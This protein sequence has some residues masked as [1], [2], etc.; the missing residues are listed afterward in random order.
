MDAG[1]VLHEESVAGALALARGVRGRV[2]NRL[3][4]NVAKLEALFAPYHRNDGGYGLIEPEEAPTMGG[5]EFPQR[6]DAGQAGVASAP[7]MLWTTV[8]DG[9]IAW[10]A[11]RP[12]RQISEA[13]EPDSRHRWRLS[14]PGDRRQ[15]HGADCGR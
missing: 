5:R 1:A 3:K 9:S 14:G 7:V 11:G 8:P 2:F 6:I 15:G 13:G 4:A 12:W 10:R